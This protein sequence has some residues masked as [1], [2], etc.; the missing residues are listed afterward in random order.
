MGSGIDQTTGE[1]RGKKI[2]ESVAL[3]ENTAHEAAGFL[4]E[5]FQR[6]GGCV[7]VETAHSDAEQGAA[8]QKL[9]VVLGEA[10]TLATIVSR[11]HVL[12]KPLSPS[13]AAHG[14]SYRLAGPRC[15]A[16]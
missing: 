6:S 16:G 9:R 14:L 2:S 4:R 10:G 13:F 11:G 8:S 12:L 1:G 15:L 5:I 7:S 3:L